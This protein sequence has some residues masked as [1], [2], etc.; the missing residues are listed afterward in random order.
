[1][2]ERDASK[3][4]SVPVL[5]YCVAIMGLQG[6]W[7]SHKYSLY[8]SPYRL[9]TRNP[10]RSPLPYL[11]LR[12]ALTLTVRSSCQ[13]SIYRN[14]YM[15][16]KDTNHVMLMPGQLPCKLSHG[17][18]RLLFDGKHFESYKRNFR[19][20]K[21]FW[22]YLWSCKPFLS[23]RQPFARPNRAGMRRRSRRRAGDTTRVLGE[24]T[25]I[26]DHL[27]LARRNDPQ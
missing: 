10:W 23:S 12:F 14:V 1:M 18:I 21:F 6:G 15:M 4:K 7:T 24:I 17:N 11:H 16:K 13:F 19:S 20:T 9:L 27:A 25:I 8:V 3:H 26:I 2:R 22:K 5:W